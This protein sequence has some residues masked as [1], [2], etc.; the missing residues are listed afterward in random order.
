MFSLKPGRRIRNAKLEH[1]TVS[2]G[3]EAGSLGH[4]TVPARERE[5]WKCYDALAHGSENLGYVT[6]P[7]AR[8]LENL[9]HVTM[10]FA[11]E[12]GNLG[13]LQCRV[14]NGRKPGTC[15]SAVCFACIAWLGTQTCDMLRRHGVNA[16][17]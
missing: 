3:K 9:G 15:Y 1:V 14:P 12:A 2:W 10:P 6:V 4:V 13:K 7:S 17:R 16:R 5:T 11:M 8:E